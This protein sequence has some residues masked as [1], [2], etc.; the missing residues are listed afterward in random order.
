[1]AAEGNGLLTI[2]IGVKC[3]IR[4]WVLAAR[5]WEVLIIGQ[6]FAEK[7]IVLA[8]WSLPCHGAPTAVFSAPS[9]VG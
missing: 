5:G 3:L 9:G 6:E 2:G 1:M 7:A 8:V 4:G